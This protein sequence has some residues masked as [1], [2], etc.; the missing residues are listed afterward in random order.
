MFKF[1]S[2]SKKILSTVDADLILIA[3]RALE[4]TRVDFG[5]PSTGGLRTAEDQNRLFL[6][7]KSKADGYDK[8]SNHQS[9]NALD[10]YAYVDGKASWD[11]GHLSMVASA[12]LQAAS[13]LNISLQWGG[14]WK[15][16]VDAPHFQ[17]RKTK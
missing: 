2:K 15:N 11:M 12:M 6:D 7:G 17:L 13:E 4:L 10:V 1:G 5:F 14:L 16:F 8:L 9:G 3:N